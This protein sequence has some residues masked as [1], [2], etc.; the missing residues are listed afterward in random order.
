MVTWPKP[1]QWELLGKR[2]QHL[3]LSGC[4]T[5][6]LS[7]EGFACEWGQHRGRQSQEI[8][9]WK[10]DLS[11]W[12]QPCLK[13]VYLWFSAQRRT[14][15]LGCLQSIKTTFELPMVR[16]NA[17]ILEISIREK[18]TRCVVDKCLLSCLGKASWRRW[19]VSWSWRILRSSQI[20]EV[21]QLGKPS[22]KG[23]V[24]GKHEGASGQRDICFQQLV[25]L[26]GRLAQRIEI[27][28]PN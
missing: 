18:G 2:T 15:P 3:L 9:P 27:F 22:L 10:H 24:Q 20:W 13:L 14:E 17:C 5:G 16:G 8:E 4:K 26:G 19:G 25:M 6:P 21:W 23:F 1:D 28:V 11:C 7:W 12:I